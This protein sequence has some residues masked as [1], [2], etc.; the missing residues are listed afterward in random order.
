MNVLIYV[1]YTSS[2]FNKDF[3][4]SNRLTYDNSVFLVTS[5]EQLQMAEKHYDILI[6]GF[7]A[8]GVNIETVIPCIKV[9]KLDT[10]ESII[11]KIKG[12][13]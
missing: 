12:V 1:D 7:S 8:E 5:A 4:L 13:S 10:Y 3:Q 2:E 11:E 9:N 6:V